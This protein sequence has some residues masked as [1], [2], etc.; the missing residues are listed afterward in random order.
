[1]ENFREVELQAGSERRRS[2]EQ[3]AIDGSQPC[4]TITKAAIEDLGALN[5]V[6]NLADPSSIEHGHEG[7]IGLTFL[8][9]YC[10]RCEA[11]LYLRFCVIDNN[12]PR[13][14]LHEPLCGDEKAPSGD[15]LLPIGISRPKIGS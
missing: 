1:M 7:L 15:T 5:L 3:A 11:N 10:V 13:V 9:V 4:N 8:R 2:R 12:G 14:A 6:D